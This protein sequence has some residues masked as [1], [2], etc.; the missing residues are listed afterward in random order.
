MKNLFPT[1]FSLKRCFT[2]DFTY[3][4]NNTTNLPHNDSHMYSINRYSHPVSNFAAL[5]LVQRTTDT[6]S[7]RVNAA[8]CFYISTTSSDG[9]WNASNRFDSIYRLLIHSWNTFD[10]CWFRFDFARQE[11]EKN[12]VFSCLVRNIRIWTKWIVNW[13]IK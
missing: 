6:C 12:I 2:R 13:M 4:C 3:I 9:I 1:T 10:W 8:I 5:F 7:Y 11:W